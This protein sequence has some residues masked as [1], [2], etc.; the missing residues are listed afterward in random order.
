M[1]LDAKFFNRELSWLEFNQRVLDEALSGDLPV[2]ER[3]T[4][5]AI[6]GS[7]LDEFFMVRVGGL[8]ML[9]KSSGTKPDPSGLTATEQLTAIRQRVCRMVAD[10][11][12]CLENELMPLLNQVGIRRASMENL[13]QR[14]LSQLERLFDE[15]I[16]SVLSP[17]A[18]NSREDFP[19]VTSGLLHACVRLERAPEL[20]LKAT[21]KAN[22]PADRF[23][24]IPFEEI[25]PRL[26]TIPSDGGY[27]FVLLE[28]AVCYFADR[29]F[30]GQKILDFVPFRVAL[31]AD[32][33]LREDVASDLMS[34]MEET[35]DARTE[36]ACVRLEIAHEASDAV[37]AFLK[38]A[39][40][41]DD[42]QIYR[43]AGPL[44][45]SA[46]MQLSGI[47]GFDNAK[48]ERWS[49]QQSP[50]YD[51]SISAFKNMRDGDMLLYHPYQSFEPIV[52]FI[53]ESS[54]D[55][56][57]LAIKQTLYRVS[58][59]SSIV[60]ALI[61]AA[62]L[63]K[64]V[65]VI[66]ELKARFDERRNIHW[67]KQLEQSGATVL[68]GV[69]G[70]KTHAKICVVTRRDSDGIRRYCHFGTGN[71]NENTAKL[72]SDAS[73]LT[74]DP[75]MGADATDFFNAITGY[76]Q[77]NMFRKLEA[78]PIGL[79]ERLVE[80]IDFEIEQ[81]RQDQPALISVKLNSLVD[82]SLIE[83]LYEASSA[84]VK[85]RLNV[86]GICCLRPGVPGLSENIEV[87]S[88]IDRFL[89]HARIIHFHHDGD[90]RV[91]ISS[92]DWMNRNLSGR[93]ELLVPVEDKHCKRQLI[94]ILDTAFADNQ[95]A[96]R[97]MPDGLYQPVRPTA[98]SK[99]AIR[100]QEVLY[101]RACEASKLAKR[102]ALTMLQPHYSPSARK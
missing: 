95:K 11:Y 31:N 54:E 29:F 17:I 35:L 43:A 79:R 59:N 65:T 72:Y 28:D 99:A 87:I 68:Y 51:T 57:V 42:D 36:G 48:Y 89:E 56:D 46:F 60:S 71:Y 70:L 69:K 22:E 10:Q 86:R 94:D 102:A 97:L 78:A 63:G 27:E 88:I 90:E 21:S 44:D 50:D 18:I 38:T 41:V 14:Q 83:K 67:A 98:G 81:A 76:S 32:V 20:M 1:S 55:P 37:V 33:A 12:H 45:L 77:P 15:E 39:L 74:C 3:L 80:L 49:P 2:L 24:I 16:Y 96:R 23:V 13:N 25:L 85:I 26:L 66:V 53:S 5:L 40:D 61:R 6:T 4:F 100:S 93:V 7:N 19:L 101:E 62:E 91:F 92:A 64:A 30:K 73:L 8:Q 52:R 9:A 47:S 58:K 82:P 34:E 84:G 75:E